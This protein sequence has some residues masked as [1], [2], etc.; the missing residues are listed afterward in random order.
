MLRRVE[1]PEIPIEW[2]IEGFTNEL[3]QTLHA[4]NAL[5]FATQ[6][7]CRAALT[8]SRLGE[9]RDVPAAQVYS[10]VA[11]SF[12]E[13]PVA[14]PSLRRPNARGP[15]RE[16][17]G[18]S[19]SDLLELEGIAGFANAPFAGAPSYCPESPVSFPSR[20]RPFG[21]RGASDENLQRLE[22][23]VALS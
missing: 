2:N 9:P 15:L 8:R 20:R 13:S 21:Y 23:E 16:G 22:D 6:A 18:D 4:S 3:S 7:K 17:S 12:P 1:G 19:L 14:V 11:M 10:S 5:L